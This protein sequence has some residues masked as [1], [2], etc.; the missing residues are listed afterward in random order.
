MGTHAPLAEQCQTEGQL[1][2]PIPAQLAALGRWLHEHRGA[3]LRRGEELDRAG[4]ANL[5]APV[6]ARVLR[7]SEAATE[8]FAR[9]L[10][11]GD[12][13]SSRAASREAAAVFS[14]LAIAHE[15]PLKELAKRTLRWRDALRESLDAG[16]DEIGL[17]PEALGEAH[18]MLRRSADVT[19]I[20]LCETFE[21]ELSVANGELARRQQELE[22]LATHD[23]LTGLPNR[24]LILD[25][26]EQMLA[27]ARRERALYAALFVDIDGFKAINDGLGHRAGD[28]LLQAVA[29]RLEGTIREVDTLGRLGSDEFVILADGIALAAG[30]E[31]VAERVLDALRQPFELQ[32]AEIGRASITASI[33]VVVA[34]E[35]TAAELLR[36]A[37]I[38]MYRAKLAGK[39]RYAVY[40]SG[41]QDAVS[42]SLGLEMDLRE[43]VAGRKL[44]L[45][46]QPIFSLDGLV[47]VRMEALLRWRRQPDAQL[48]PPSQFVP[49][50]EQSGLIAE[51]GRWVLEQACGQ[52]ARWAREGPELGVAV[53]ASAVQ[54]EQDQFVED[55]A[56]AVAQSGIDPGMLT[57][58]ITETALMRDA[59]RTGERLRALKKLGVR[60]SID[61]FGTGYSSLAYLQR[62][63][64]D[65]LKIDRSFISAL[66]STTQ[67]DALIR[68][69]VQIGRSLRIETIAEGIENHAQLE[70]LQAE[71]CDLGQ[72]FLFAQPLEADECQ[73]FLDRWATVSE[74][75]PGTSP[76]SAG[77]WRAR[78]GPRARR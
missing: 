58:E 20:R 31:L 40:E 32:G 61:D 27:R 56:G 65:E 78:S 28:A 12:T 50:L 67:H 34:A 63:P 59:E 23:P 30:P 48:V 14:Q 33:G 69:F 4:G 42:A 70:R 36:D 26:A 44:Y 74:R 64:V 39:N 16:A 76:A 29:T 2:Q 35:H 9:W 52:C 7:V 51:V 18:A 19:L 37:D 66:E 25:R 46:Y 5:D 71:G 41:M 77:R 38:A 3:A 53:N 8:A 1:S 54:L 15:S 22:F 72:G 55:V 13:E 57:I 6:T 21:Q 45:V 62:F 68:A 47:P 24:T 49:L 73:P 17:S 75:P 11:C 10:T 60:L 43:A